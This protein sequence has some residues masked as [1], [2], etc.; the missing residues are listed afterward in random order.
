MVSVTATV[1]E[2]LKAWEKT[3]RTCTATQT[4][5]MAGDESSPREL[6][7]EL[8]DEKSKVTRLRVAENPA[9]PLV[10][11]LKLSLDEDADVRIA[12]AENASS[13][14]GLKEFLSKD[15]SADVRYAMAENANT[16]RSILQGLAHD[17]NPYVSSR[18]LRTLSALYPVPTP[19]LVLNQVSTVTPIHLSA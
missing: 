18:A 1:M 19:V 12:V 8:A 7:K 4:Y 13:P 6:L 11:L 10:V 15:E 9:T 16:D 2:N 14:L 17:E 3:I 5:L